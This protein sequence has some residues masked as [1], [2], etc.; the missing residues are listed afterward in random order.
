MEILNRMTLIVNNRINENRV[1]FSSPGM[2]FLSF[3]IY[4]NT[5]KIRTVTA[6]AKLK[7]T[8]EALRILVDL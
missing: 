7:M 6:I 3:K 2:G 5:V 8:E 1:R 4:P